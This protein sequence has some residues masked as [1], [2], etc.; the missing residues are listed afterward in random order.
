MGKI[1]SKKTREPGSRTPELDRLLPVSSKTYI[2]DPRIS[3]VACTID[4]KNIHLGYQLKAAKPD[5]IVHCK[6]KGADTRKYQVLEG[7][8]AESI[9][10]KRCKKRI[11]VLQNPQSELSKAV[12]KQQRY[13][14]GEYAVGLEVDGNRKTTHLVIIPDGSSTKDPE[15]R[16]FCGSLTQH[17]SYTFLLDYDLSKISCKFCRE[18]FSK[19]PQRD[20]DGNP[21]GK[22]DL[23][24]IMGTGGHAGVEPTLVKGAN[25]GFGD[26]MADDDLLRLDHESD[27]KNDVF[28]ITKYR[29]S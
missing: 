17:M 5:L 1:T 23:W 7:E 6:R 25:D 2:Y 10:C 26:V 21:F 11:S 19:L 29:K 22:A 14:H 27:E 28:S 3:Y 8:D 18:H 16:P 24:F 15:L 13:Y 20:Q 9:N 4:K 12:S